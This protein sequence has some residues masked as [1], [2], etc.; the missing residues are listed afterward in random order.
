MKL[1]VDQNISFRVSVLLKDTFPEIRHVREFDLQAAT[2]RHIWN[3]AKE[4][5][6]HIVTFDSD[7]YDMVT[8]YGHPP[9]IIWLRLGNTS[10]QNLIRIIQAQAETIKSFLTDLQHENMSCLEICNL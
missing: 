6:Y 7:F 8:L 10:S 4:N 2:D 9:K 5:H 3:F 1:L